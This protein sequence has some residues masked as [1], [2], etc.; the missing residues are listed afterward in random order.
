[1]ARLFQKSLYKG[2]TR[3]ILRESALYVNGNDRAAVDQLRVESGALKDRTVPFNRFT[4]LGALTAGTRT[5]GSGVTQIHGGT[6]N[7]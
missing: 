6:F 2:A 5:G 4:P 7:G 3:P 1:M